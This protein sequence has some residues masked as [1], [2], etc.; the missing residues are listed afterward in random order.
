MGI[1]ADGCLLGPPPPPPPPQPASTTKAAAQTILI[2]FIV[3][4]SASGLAPLVLNVIADG[5]VV[6]KPRV[7]ETASPSTRAEKYVA[8]LPTRWPEIR[9]EVDAYSVGGQSPHTAGRNP[10]T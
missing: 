4:P 2:F 9:A 7:R 6:S 3:F 1:G 10:V 5:R 8:A